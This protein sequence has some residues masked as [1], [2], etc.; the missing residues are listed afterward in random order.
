LFLELK[1]KLKYAPIR[2]LFLGLSARSKAMNWQVLL[3][4]FEEAD[5]KTGAHKKTGE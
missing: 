4:T 1:P 3:Q 5:Q 2:S